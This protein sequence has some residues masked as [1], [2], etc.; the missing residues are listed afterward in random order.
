M[1][2]L[3]KI[4]RNV[5]DGSIL[6]EKE[7]RGLLSNP[8]EG[9]ELITGEELDEKWESF[10]SEYLEQIEDVL[11]EIID[12]EAVQTFFTRIFPVDLR[13]YEDMTYSFVQSNNFGDN[14]IMCSVLCP[15]VGS[16]DVP[17]TDEEK[18]EYIIN[19]LV[20]NIIMRLSQQGARVEGV[21]MTIDRIKNW[22]M[23]NINELKKMIE[24]VEREC[25]E[26]GLHSDELGL[27]ITSLPT[28]P[29][30]GG[31]ADYPVWA[32]DRTGMCLVGDNEV[33]SLKEIIES[34]KDNRTV[35]CRACN[36]YGMQS[37]DEDEPVCPECGAN[38]QWEDEVTISV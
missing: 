23:N 11:R 15:Q 18:L 7:W 25:D 1:T 20:D 9:Y 34:Y 31:V 10:R 36:K 2:N 13:I 12:D 5:N 26:L 37:K 14:H 16:I 4:Y 22:N 28:T 17:D 21:R 33:E 27:D 24:H 38:A 30:P 35:Y 29:V 32:C 19:R 6:T 3:N 8:D